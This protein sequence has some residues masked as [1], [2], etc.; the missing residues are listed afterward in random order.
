[1]W[2]VEWQEGSIR[3]HAVRCFWRDALRWGCQ[4]AGR[5]GG[6][7]RV[8]SEQTYLKEPA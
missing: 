7:V 1:M 5:W 2:V 6:P 8:M 3:H 4:M